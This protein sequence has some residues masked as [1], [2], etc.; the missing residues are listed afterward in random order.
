MELYIAHTEVM[1]Q[2][3]DLP[4]S[5]NRMQREGYRVLVNKN[6]KNTE[7]TGWLGRPLER[8]DVD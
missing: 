5:V 3:G 4:G 6:R 8:R 2:R 1:K 7:V